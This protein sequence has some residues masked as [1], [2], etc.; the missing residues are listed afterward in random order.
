MT[1]FELGDRVTFTAEYLRRWLPP[2]GKGDGRKVWVVCPLPKWNRPGAREGIVVGLRT[3]SNG[4][5]TY[6]Y[7]AG[8]DYRADDTVPAVLI[9]FDIRRKP[10]LCPPAHVKKVAA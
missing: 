8:P 1:A 7:D 9:A 4:T 6:N 2:S 5:I 10:I 3:L